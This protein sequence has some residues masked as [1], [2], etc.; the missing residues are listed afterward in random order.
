MIILASDILGYKDISGLPEGNIKHAAEKFWNNIQT[1]VKSDSWFDIFIKSQLE[2]ALL[3]IKE[4]LD[5]NRPSAYTK[6]EDETLHCLCTQLNE[7]VPP[8]GFTMDNEGNPQCDV[9][10]F[11]HILYAGW[12]AENYSKDVSFYSINRLC[13]HG[14]MQQRGIDL[15]LEVAM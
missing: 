5:E 11:R 12:I 4:L 1:N 13:E 6:P 15:F 14:I 10:D 2:N 3:K 9:I 7:L 8:V